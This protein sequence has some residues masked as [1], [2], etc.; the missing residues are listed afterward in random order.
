MSIK[1][2]GYCRV[3]T[4][5]QNEERQVVAMKEFG[6]FEENIIVEK[7]SGKNFDRPL[8]QSL[9][10]KLKADDVLVI[11]S[12]DRLGRDYDSIISEWRYITKNLNVS[13][14]VLDMPLLDTRQK[15]R[16]LTVSFVSDLVLQILSYVA[17]TERNFNRQR[18]AEGIAIAKANGVRLGRKP[19]E[20]PP[21]F[22]EF[23]K[24][25]RRGEISA[26]EAARELGVSRPTFMK[27]LDEK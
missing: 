1:V 3:S 25:W 19:L 12:L 11:K 10:K 24:L 21:A 4:R 22:R 15:D 27:W 2:I 16:D 17:E 8:Y 7:M 18:Q 14:V 6:V 23:S 20:V 5:E 13:I 26:S 9:L